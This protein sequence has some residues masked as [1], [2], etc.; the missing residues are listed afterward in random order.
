MSDLVEVFHHAVESLQA[1]KAKINHKITLSRDQAKASSFIEKT[2]KNLH[3]VAIKLNS[4]PSQIKSID[5]DAESHHSSGSERAYQIAKLEGENEQLQESHTSL[6]RDFHH[7][8]KNVQEL[9]S[10]LETTRDEAD[11]ERIRHEQLLEL[12]KEEIRN[13]KSV[14][15][16]IQGA[17]IRAERDRDEMKLL[18]RE[19]TGVE[20]ED[21][22]EY[23]VDGEKKKDDEEGENSAE[24]QI[25]QHFAQPKNSHRLV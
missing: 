10:R 25:A 12:Y 23:L 13:V 19:L 5:S 21:E 2:I 3:K 8:I 22:G 9:E 16:E 4:N 17:R 20:M 15:E 24:Q 11:I 7:W 18:L 1:V 6:R 14:I